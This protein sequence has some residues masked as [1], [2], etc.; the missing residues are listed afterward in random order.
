MNF[1]N[2][3]GHTVVAR[4]RRST[5]NPLVADAASRFDLRWPGGQR[6]HRAAVRQSQRRQPGVRAGRLPVHR[7]GRR[8]QR[9][10]TRSTARRTGAT[11]LGKMLRIDVT[12]P[13]AI[14]PGYD[15]P[16]DNPFVG[17]AGRAAGDLGV[18]PAQSVALQL[19]RSGARRHRRAGHRR[20]RAERAGRK[21]TTS[22]RGAAA[23]TTAGAI[24]KA[25]TTTS[26]APRGVPAAD[27]S[28]LRVRT[29]VGAGG[30]RRL[31]V[32]GRRWPRFGGR[33]FFAD[34]VAS[35]VWSL[36]LDVDAAHRRGDATDLR[37]H[38]A[39]LG[40]AG[41]PQRH[42]LV[43][44]RCGRRAL[45]RVARRRTRAAR[46]AGRLAA[47]HEHRHARGGRGR[48][49]AVRCSAAGRST[50]SRAP[51]PA[52]TRCTSGHSAIPAPARRRCSLVSLVRRR[53]PD[54]AAAYGP[55]AALSGFG[56]TVTGLAPGSIAWWSSAGSPRRED[57]RSS[58]RST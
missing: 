22:R 7:P 11:L 3:A 16:A 20:R 44:R 41:V 13:T 47:A 38:T 51:A 43:R 19:R 21:S 49:S 9:R 31:R 2:A 15:V 17:V 50:S 40:G 29:R 14:P 35:R 45:S 26:R 53:R 30:H 4:F 10:T 48:P 39:E 24:A 42:Q 54:V 23:A 6:V 5:G 27:R 46:P 8:R 28:D 25:R 56:L 12:C 18:R 34:F 52:S 36:A 37:E 55:Q 1:T 58:A 33:Y 32:S 57:S